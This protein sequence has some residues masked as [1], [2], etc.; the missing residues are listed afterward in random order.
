MVYDKREGSPEWKDPAKVLAQ[1]G[2]VLFL[3]QDTG[4][5]KAHV[6]RVQ[7][8]KSLSIQYT[9]PENSHDNSNNTHNI[10]NLDKI[11]ASFKTNENN[12]ESSDE[13]STTSIPNI[14][15]QTN[16][17][18]KTTNSV[19]TN[20]KEQNEKTKNLI[21][22]PN[23]IITF[24]DENIHYEADMISR[25]GKSTGNIKYY[26]P[27]NAS[28]TQTWIDLSKVKNLLII[29]ERAVSSFQIIIPHQ[30]IFCQTNM[31]TVIQ[32]AK[33]VRSRKFIC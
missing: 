19:S 25:A 10:D 21:I 31:L 18:D 22:K 27:S 13:E 23:Q 24:I 7:S 2:P 14:E 11:T 26:S 4:Y 12:N 16:F 30:V 28:G 3:R 5:I 6:C 1:D 17:S 29:P 32:K 8:I 15:K 33:K 20:H 9:T